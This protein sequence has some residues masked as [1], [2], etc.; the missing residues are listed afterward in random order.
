VTAR[1]DRCTAVKK[2]KD[3]QPIGIE[4]AK[5]CTLLNDLTGPRSGQMPAI[6]ENPSKA[7]AFYFPWPHFRLAANVHR[8]RS[9][10]LVKVMKCQRN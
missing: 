9:R 8:Y 7:P 6:L 10:A 1:P 2:R 5:L 3:L 4:Y